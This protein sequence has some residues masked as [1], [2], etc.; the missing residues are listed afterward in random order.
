MA[1]E[2]L[3]DSAA[4]KLSSHGYVTVPFLRMNTNV[5]SQD[6]GVEGLL[7]YAVSVTV[8]IEIL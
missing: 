8:C 4:V 1:V 5:S 6:W 2:T 7:R 3:T